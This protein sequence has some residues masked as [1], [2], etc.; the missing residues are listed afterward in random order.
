MIHAYDRSYLEKARRTLAH[1]L[2]HAVHT[3]GMD[4]QD[5]YA[6]FLISTISDRFQTGDCSVIAGRSGQELVMM[7]LEETSYPIPDSGIN[8]LPSVHVNG[9]TPEYWTG[10]ALAY[11]QWETGMSF[12]QIERSVPITEIRDLYPAFH[13]LDILHFCDT[14]RRQAATK[15]METRLKYYRRKLGLSQRQLAENADIPVRTIQQYE[16]RQKN[17]NK[18]QAEYLIRLASVLG[19]SEREL[20]EE[21]V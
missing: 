8:A 12:A 14:M 18:A 2:N 16:Q 19:C 4:L 21:Q 7:T 3:F 17:I 5:F 13:E 20:M 11:F 10:W 6:L 15:N 1:M 9:R